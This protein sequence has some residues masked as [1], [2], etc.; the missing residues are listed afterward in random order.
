MKVPSQTFRNYCNTNKCNTIAS[1]WN[2][3]QHFVEILDIITLL[4]LHRWEYYIQFINK[5]RLL[6]K[7]QFLSVTKPQQL[8][9]LY[10]VKVK[11]FCTSSNHLFLFFF[12]VWKYTYICQ[13]LFLTKTNQQCCCPSQN[14]VTEAL[15]CKMGIVSKQR[16]APSHDSMWAG[17]A[18]VNS[19]KK[20]SS[21]SVLETIMCSSFTDYL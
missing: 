9:F 3:L 13:L 10:D 20:T 5:T 2:T 21:S 4:H 11:Y 1:A 7:S 16:N 18:T 15:Y 19:N 12:S 17:V 6:F 14:V 8:H